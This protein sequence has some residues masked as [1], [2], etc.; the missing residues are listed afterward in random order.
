MTNNMW[1]PTLVNKYE[2]FKIKEIL[3][4]KPNSECLISKEDP[5]PFWGGEHTVRG[6]IGV[7]S[8]NLSSLAHFYILRPGKH[9]LMIKTFRLCLSVMNSIMSRTL[10]LWSQVA[11]IYSFG[12][13][14]NCVVSGAFALIN[15]S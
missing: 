15:S 11:R 3:C 13:C 8:I 9:P 10:Y 14:N 1:I 5:N 12:K 6:V 2:N 4:K 7:S